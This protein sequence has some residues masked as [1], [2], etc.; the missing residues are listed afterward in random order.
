VATKE[1]Q[2]GRLS[3][4]YERQLRRSPTVDGKHS[5]PQHLRMQLGQKATSRHDIDHLGVTSTADESA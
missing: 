3:G 1:S 2:P 4:N 5:P